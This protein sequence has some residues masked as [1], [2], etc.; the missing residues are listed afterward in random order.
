MATSEEV[1]D[2]VAPTLLTQTGESRSPKRCK[3]CRVNV[4]E[5]FDPH[6]EATCLFGVV[7][8]LRQCIDN[9]EKTLLDGKEKH[10]LLR[11]CPA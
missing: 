7:A 1:G 9:L 4:K 5:H 3:V 11:P 8:G 6:G 10:Q 2:F